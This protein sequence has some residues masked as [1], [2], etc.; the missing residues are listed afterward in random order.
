V[1]QAE[2]AEISENPGGMAAEVVGHELEEGA[3]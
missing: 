1:K 2:A 3:T